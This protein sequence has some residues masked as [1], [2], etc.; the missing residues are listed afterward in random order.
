MSDRSRTARRFCAGSL[1]G[2]R[3][4]S[5]CMPYG[6][7][8]DTLVLIHFLWILFLIFG[9]YF[10]K[11]CAKVKYLHL[12]GLVFAAI[13]QTLDLYCPLT[14]LE[15][16]LR[17]KQDPAQSY[18]GSFIIHYIE[19]IVYVEIPRSVILI[20]TFVV[21]GIN[22]LFYFGPGIKRT[23]LRKKDKNRYN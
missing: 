13:I 15:V 14:Y 19:R 7:F 10:G 20:L 16:Y 3:V 8:A 4:L 12:L 17:H 2:F 11:R 1:C 9:V 22:L 23:I 18:S 21:V 6:V 5:L